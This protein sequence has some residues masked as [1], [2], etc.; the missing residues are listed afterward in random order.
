[1]V[2]VSLSGSF[3]VNSFLRRPDSVGALSAADWM[4]LLL[5]IDIDRCPACGEMF[6]RDLMPPMV[7]PFPLS[8]EHPLAADTSVRGPPARDTPSIGVFT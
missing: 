8:V 4:H 3:V 6:H 1:M 5:G 7:S 2:C